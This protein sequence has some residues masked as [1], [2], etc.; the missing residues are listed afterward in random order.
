MKNFG[1][2]FAR[3]LAWLM[4]VALSCWLI[5]GLLESAIQWLPLGDDWHILMSLIHFVISV[6]GAVEIANWAYA[7]DR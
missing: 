6:A 2:Q 1:R 4:T 5:F 7:W 3:G